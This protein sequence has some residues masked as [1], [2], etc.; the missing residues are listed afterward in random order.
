MDSNTEFLNFSLEF[1]P[2][3]SVNKKGEKKNVTT[4]FPYLCV[5]N[6]AGLVLIY[7][8]LLVMDHSK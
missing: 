7:Y 3:S 2:N 6:S 5:R 4:L 8:F 1:I